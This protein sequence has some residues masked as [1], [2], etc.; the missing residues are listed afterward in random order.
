MTDYGQILDAADKI[1]HWSIGLI[2]REARDE[3]ED[4]VENLRARQKMPE[5][6]NKPVGWKYPERLYKKL[7]KITTAER[8]TYKERNVLRMAA[9]ITGMGTS[10][11]QWPT[12]SDT[13]SAKA[14]ASRLEQVLVQYGGKL[15]KEGLTF[16]TNDIHLSHHDYE[17]EAHIGIL[18]VVISVPDLSFIRVYQSPASTHDNDV[19]HPH[20]SQGDHAVCFGDVGGRFKVYAHGGYVY[21]LAEFL[22]SLLNTYNHNSPL[23]EITAWLGDN[24]EDASECYNC[25][26]YSHVDEIGHCEG[27]DHDHCGECLPECMCCGCS[28]YCSE[29]QVTCRECD[30]E[31]CPECAT[32]SRWDSQRRGG[33]NYRIRRYYCDDCT[34]KC[35]GCYGSFPKTIPGLRVTVNNHFTN[36]MPGLVYCEDCA[37]QEF[38]IQAVGHGVSLVDY[39]QFSLNKALTEYMAMDVPSPVTS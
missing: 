20:V 7:L 1:N 17:G 39:K 37:I 8:Y 18:K 25:G 36:N 30:A 14:I 11:D 21:E 35:S 13:L 31:L 3:A 4:R 9:E 33:L 16:F 5:A 29:C 15:D 34:E 24:N 38:S 32:T 2:A 23:N 12:V 26:V 19:T 27:C 22:M 28:Q 10:C 6:Y